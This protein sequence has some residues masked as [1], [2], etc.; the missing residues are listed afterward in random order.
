MLAPAQKNITPILQ[1]KIKIGSPEDKYEQEADAVA[2]QVMKMPEPPAPINPIQTKEEEEELRMKPL[3]NSITP[4]VQKQHEEEEQLQLKQSDTGTSDMDGISSKLSNS[5]GKGA[6]LPSSTNNQMSRSF[7]VDFSDVKIHT[8]NEAIQMNR[9]LNAKA[10]T[11]GND[12][13]FNKGEYNPQSYSGKHLL[14]HEL[15]HTVQHGHNLI[16][17]K[18]Y[19][20]EINNYLGFFNGYEDGL[21]ALDFLSNLGKADFN[22]TLLSM[23]KSGSV[24]RLITQLNGRKEVKRLLNLIAD[25]ATESN[26]EYF[27]KQ[28]ALFVFSPENNLIL[29]GRKFSKNLGNRGIVIS[30]LFQASVVSSNP[31]EPFTGSGASGLNAADSPMGISELWKMRS[32]SKDAKNKGGVD[33]AKYIKQPGL[34]MLY[35]WS[36]PI[37]GNLVG[38]SSYLSGLTAVERLNQVKVLFGQEINTNYKGAYS[39]KLP[40]RVQVLRA[41]SIQH[42]LEPELIAAII[43]AEQRDQSKREDAVDYQGAILA[44]RSSS[45]GL[46]QV[47]VN[48]ARKE[49]LFSDLISKELQSRLSSSSKVG[50]PDIVRMLASD[51][52]NI[53]AVAKYLRIVANMGASMNISA[54]NLRRTATWLGAINLSLFANNSS[55]WT[56]NHIRLIGS[57][58]TSKPFDDGLVPGWGEFV[59]EAYKDVKKTKIFF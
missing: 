25:L 10:F 44:G 12:I 2:D 57:E 50:T 37:K 27:L 18:S 7:G 43:L 6:S 59:F 51:E 32:Q 54:P 46:G 20:N 45:I 15:T 31:S 40:T 48:T 13:Y 11:Y 58:Y 30:S 33:K 47:T 17:R 52:F 21:K 56:D 22:D 24:S 49:N 39:K 5:K 41:A 42:N 34:E 29:F 35:D 3:L 4:I 19:E 16:Q 28:N 8:N 9:S 23:S 36:N 26:K 38:G 55:L 14:A 53:F 1:P